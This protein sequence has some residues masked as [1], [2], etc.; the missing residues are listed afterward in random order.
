[1][2]NIE[3]EKCK[4]FSRNLQFQV[5]SGLCKTKVFTLVPEIMFSNNELK[6]VRISKKKKK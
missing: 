4:K 2:R 3:A 1:M 5:L 6:R